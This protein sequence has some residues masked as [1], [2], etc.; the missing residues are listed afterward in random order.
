M[1]TPLLSYSRHFAAKLE[2]KLAERFGGWNSVM[3]ARGK[4]DT[5]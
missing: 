3:F 4:D 5:D 1:E 2:L